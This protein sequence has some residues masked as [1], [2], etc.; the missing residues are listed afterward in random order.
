MPNGLRKLLDKK[1]NSIGGGGMSIFILNG[2]SGHI[3]SLLISK[4]NGYYYIHKCLNK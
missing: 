1:E 3:W 2:W 4:L